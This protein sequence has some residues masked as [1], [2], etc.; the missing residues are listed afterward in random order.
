MSQTLHSFQLN[1]PGPRNNMSCELWTQNVP[2]EPYLNVNGSRKD[3]SAV[4]TSDTNVKARSSKHAPISTV[5][6][7]QLLK[8]DQTPCH[9]PPV[10]SRKGGGA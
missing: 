7:E 2:R 3:T 1:E 9:S 5:Y 6:A 10:P 4:P 8:H